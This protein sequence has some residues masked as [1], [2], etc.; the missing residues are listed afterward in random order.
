MEIERNK[1][2]CEER[3]KRMRKNGRNGMKR[4]ETRKW[5]EAE[6]NGKKLKEIR[7]I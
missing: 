4:K 6:R 2:K 1:K 5:D 7:S 3:E